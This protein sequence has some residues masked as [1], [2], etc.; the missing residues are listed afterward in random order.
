LAE[1][2]RNWSP[3][4]D[5]D[6]GTWVLSDEDQAL[7]RQLDWRRHRR[8]RIFRF[9]AAVVA[10][11]L[12]AVSA[13]TLIGRI[14]GGDDGPDPIDQERID[15]GPTSE[16]MAGYLLSDAEVRDVDPTLE[17]LSGN[18]DGNGDSYDNLS[19]DELGAGGPTMPTYG[20]GAGVVRQWAS[21]DGRAVTVGI[22]LFPDRGTAAR[23][24]DKVLD[25]ATAE[26]AASRE[27]ADFAVSVVETQITEW[28]AVLSI[29]RFVVTFQTIA[30]E[31]SDAS[32][33]L[34]AASEAS[35][36]VH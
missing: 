6:D 12:L 17:L 15:A 18:T 4:E 9:A 25:L 31:A 3:T 1:D 14:G 22:Y 21:A 7:Q 29:G 30:V 8:G 5:V 34:E 20:A 13:S 2:P 26:G 33:L 35:A 27:L 23:A 11:A 28:I 10:V 32:A 16:E 19:L 36:A 24:R